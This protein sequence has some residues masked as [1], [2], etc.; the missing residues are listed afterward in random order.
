MPA[1]AANNVWKA[2][3]SKLLRVAKSDPKRAGVLVVLVAVLGTMW[4]RMGMTDGGPQQAGGATAAA[5]DNQAAV[6]AR[7]AGRGEGQAATT[8]ALNEWRSAPLSLGVRNLFAVQLDNYAQSGV[9]PAAAAR[10]D[11]GFW[12]ALAKSLSSRAD[13]NKQRHI[14]TE[15]A[16]RDAS[17]LQLQTIVMGASPRAVIDGEMVGI[18]SVVA[19]FRVSK[20]EAR[21][22]IVEREGIKLEIPIN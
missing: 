8:A 14:R 6:R 16:V 19:G 11:D 15:N 21:R 2:A 10:G 18:G 17:K 1:P 3:V 9:A 13:Q 7:S 5:T 22:I 4:A 12:E 20:I